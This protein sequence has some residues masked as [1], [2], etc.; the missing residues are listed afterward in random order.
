MTTAGYTYPPPTEVPPR[1]YREGFWVLKDRLGAI[2]WGALNWQGAV[3]AEQSLELIAQTCADVLDSLDVWLEPTRT[4]EHSHSMI[5]PCECGRERSAPQH[6]SQ[7]AE[8]AQTRGS[9]DGR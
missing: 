8:T 9:N 4:D 2:H 1:D 3:T 5:G 6:S 7:S